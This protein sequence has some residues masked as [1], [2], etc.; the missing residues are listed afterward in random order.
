[1]K[2]KIIGS[3]L[4]ASVLSVGAF[5]QNHYDKN[6]SKS[7]SICKSDKKNNHYKMKRGHNRGGI[8]HL[9]KKLN[10]DDSQKTKIRSIMRDRKSNKETIASSFTSTSFD[11]KKYINIIKDKKE[12]MLKLRANKIEKIYKVLNSKQKTQL[13]VLIDLK[14]EKKG[15]H[16][17][18]RFNGRG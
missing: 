11:K 15:K 7:S 2:N 1:M 10:L 5:A 16:F 18:K 17:D 3:L 13:K 14:A 6:D 12:N 9:V 4:I 8:L